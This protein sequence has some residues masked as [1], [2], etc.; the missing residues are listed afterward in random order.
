M[1]ARP[2]AVER[3]TAKGANGG[4]LHDDACAATR[5]AAA[6]A[7]AAAGATGAAI[8]LVAHRAA[9]LFTTRRRG[10]RGRRGGASAHRGVSDT[11]T[12][13]DDAATTCG[14]NTGPLIFGIVA[15]ERNDG[16]ARVRNVQCVV[17]DVGSF[18][19][20]DD[21]DNQVAVTG[22]AAVNPAFQ[23]VGPP[24][25]VNP[26]GGS[27][28]DSVWAPMPSF[29]RVLRLYNCLLPGMDDH[30]W[31]LTGP[32]A[33]TPEPA[34]SSICNSGMDDDGWGQTGP[35]VWT[36]EPDPSITC[37]SGIDDYGWG[38]TGAEAFEYMQF[39]Y[40]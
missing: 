4:G 11:S 5:A 7:A 19:L 32:E 38:L 37:N 6:A 22:A 20:A 26:C 9:G 33:L 12:T 16:E 34:V 8:A 17:Q 21:K 30:G 27:F 10:R 36:P 14:S 1:A 3:P 24:S 18:N 39:W 35:E 2:A 28:C 29:E 40:G 31:G 25:D 23:V 13:D 15:D